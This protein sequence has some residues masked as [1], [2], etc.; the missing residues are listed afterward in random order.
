MKLGL[1]SH[2]IPS[3][4]PL[5]K[6]TRPL[7]RFSEGTLLDAIK[8]KSLFTED[9]NAS[10]SRFAGSLKNVNA[11]PWTPYIDHEQQ[12][13]H[14]HKKHKSWTQ[15]ALRMTKATGHLFKAAAKAPLALPAAAIGFSLRALDSRL[16]DEFIQLEQKG[17]PKVWTVGDPITLLNLN[18]ALSESQIMND[19]NQ[20]GDSSKRARELSKFLL[21]EDPDVICLQEAFDVDLI[22]DTLG[23]DL[24]KA[25]YN[26]TIAAKRKNH[27]GLTSGLVFAT[28]FKTDKPKFQP[29]S[30]LVSWDAAARKGVM[31]AQVHL[32]SDHSISITNTHMQGAFKQPRGTENPSEK[33][34]QARKDQFQE[35]LSF[36]EKI[37][38]AG[39]VN[40]EIIMGDFNTSRF[41]RERD[42]SVKATYDYSS[43][44]DTVLQNYKDLNQP[45][46]NAG[47]KT[48]LSRERDYDH[49]NPNPKENETGTFQGSCIN[50]RSPGVRYFGQG[51]D[52]DKMYIQPNVTDHLCMKNKDGNLFSETGY[53]YE[54]ILPVGPS[55]ILSDHKAIKVTLQANN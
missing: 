37:I 47:F 28:K 40:D 20:V 11:S 51:V 55:G 17:E 42:G 34:V 31:T 30:H 4:N 3:K 32:N 5:H 14:K 27:L 46:T 19:R 2:F 8:A 6:I 26:V 39:A 16:S 43:F 38:D 22:R 35:I 33:K 10:T 52:P 7:V 18:V 21:Q 24:Q 25:G 29:F 36:T 53:R 9:E 1:I 44:K 13:A 41:R 45:D 48:V 12:I 54:S 23:K 50:P 15:T 49:G